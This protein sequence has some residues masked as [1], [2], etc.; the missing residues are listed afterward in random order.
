[1]NAAKRPPSAPQESLDWEQVRVFL[2]VLREGSLSGASL[3]LG[4][5]ISTV[6]RRIDRLEKQLGAGL[7]DRTRDGTTP[8]LL[9]E[10]ILPHAEEMELAAIRFA[11]AGAQVET[12]VEGIIRITVF[13]GI[14]D[15]FVAPALA[16]LHARYPR[17]SVEL[18]ASIGYADL[19]RREADLAV[20]A[21]RPTSGELLA[22]KMLTA[23]SVPLAATQY[24]AELGRLR[25][26]DDA[27]WIGWG[28]DLGHLPDAAWLRKHAPNA[29]PVLR[30]SHFA[31]QLAAARAGLGVALGPAPFA[32]DGLV[33][34]ARTRA[35]DEAWS[36]LPVASLW[37]VGHR[38]LR[39][40]P[41]I[42]AVWSF[43]LE[44]FQGMAPT[45]RGGAMP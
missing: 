10:Q 37:L 38:A 40:V 16:R 42:A 33:E 12:E 7:F 11:S 2:A 27:R 17:L 6:S 19:T 32:T 36:D 15:R 8:T 39:N 24:A 4:L 44:L 30:T 25:S 18:D 45:Q 14:A 23:P 35:L 20:R 9:G 22:V 41:R 26:L 3:R 29:V 21:T 13:P 31:S 1:M 43:L 34:V 28:R 5:D